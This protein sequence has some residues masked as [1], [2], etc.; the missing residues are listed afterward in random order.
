FGTRRRRASAG[1]RTPRTLERRSRAVRVGDTRYH[2]DEA[3]VD[4]ERDDRNDRPTR[5]Q[6][7]LPRKGERG[8]QRG[9]LSAR[10]G[11]R[12]VA[13]QAIRAS[14]A[15]RG[16]TGAAGADR[17]FGRAAATLLT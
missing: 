10:Q 5:D 7:H 3:A 2:V 1:R 9:G 17:G 14:C 16:G 8:P 11:D 15:I 13:R 6:D 12:G 4:T